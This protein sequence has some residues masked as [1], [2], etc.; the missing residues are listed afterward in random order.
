M[1]VRAGRKFYLEID[2]V[3]YSERKLFRVRRHSESLRF[4]HAMKLMT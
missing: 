2:D 1:N 3:D 4:M